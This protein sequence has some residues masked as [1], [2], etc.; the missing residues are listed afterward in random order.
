[1]TV[2]MYPPPDEK[3]WPTLGPFVCDFIEDNLCF[4]PGDLLGHPVTLSD[5]L[6]AWISKMYEIEPPYVVTGK[7]KNRRR[8]KNPRTGRR[9]FQRCVLSLRKGSA[10]TEIAAWIAACELHPDGPVRC[11]GFDGDQPIPCGVTDPYI[12]MISYTEE[13]TEELAYGALR[14]ILEESRIASDFD[15]GLNRIVRVRGDGKAEAVTASPNARDGARTTFQHADEALALDTPLPTP[16]G[17]TTMGEVEPGDFLVG[18]DGR[19]CQVLGKSDVHHGRPCYRVTFEDGTSVVADANH[20]WFARRSGGCGHG[21]GCRCWRAQ[22]WGVR[23]T[24]DM[25][26]VIV[27]GDR[28]DR[29]RYHVPVGAPIETDDLPLPLDP[30][31]LG[32]WLGDGDARN[33]MVHAGFLDGEEVAEAIAQCG[34]AVTSKALHSGVRMYATT[35]D[36]LPNGRRDSV[37]G[38]LRNMS[39]LQNKHIP[40]FYLHAGTEQRLALMQGLM[41]SDGH[42]SKRGDC[43]FI[44]T[45]SALIEGFVE[46]ARSLGF[47]PTVHWKEDDRRESYRRCAKVSFQADRLMPVFRLVRKLERLR[48]VRDPRHTKLAIVSI[49]LVPSVPVQCVKVDAPDS[50]FRAGLGMIPTHNTH[51]LILDGL[52]RAWTVMLANLAKRPMADPWAL[53]TTTAPEPGTDSVAEGTMRYAYEMAEK[54]GNS[55]AR[56]FFYHRQASDKHDLDTDEG[57]RN[58]V[59]EASGPYIAKWSDIDRIVGTFREP[60]ADLPYLERVWLNRPVQAAGLAFNVERWQEL[61]QPDHVVPDGALVTLGFDGSRYDDATA[62]VATEVETGF[63]WPLGIWQ[64][65]PQLVEWE[66]PV[67]EVDGIVNDAFERWEVVRMYCDPPKWEGWIA[68]WAGRY[69]DKRV[70]EW[71]TNR[72][73][74]MAYALRAY[75]SAIR[76]GE[77]IHNGDRTLETHI[78][79]ARRLYTQL[80]DDEGKRLWILRKERPDSPKKIDAAMAAV[81]SWESRI[82]AVAEGLLVGVGDE[83]IDF[84]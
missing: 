11:A 6:R 51:R 76:A 14:R 78:A 43:T 30:Y 18:R 50:L 62:L 27:E 84:I 58:A 10:K 36:S 42:V 16:R 55:G 44:N 60:D 26:D 41:D 7:G 17:W 47:S 61:A 75:K 63:Q 1:M 68:T 21:Q 22:G 40:T 49:K 56:L 34:Y 33:A 65:P 24:E 74:P 15:I 73:K 82:D 2:F 83:G 59:V 72:R 70:V 54:T 29:F 12:P 13:Q 4:G 25:R 28:R 67:L 48:T 31:V 81:L 57:L 38:R 71:W 5:E 64:R 80:S 79:N 77:V 20:L 53:E 69:G 3:P 46:L 19:P 35:H 32:L 45:N 37:I 23:R 8:R 9:R 39:L 52:K 66:V